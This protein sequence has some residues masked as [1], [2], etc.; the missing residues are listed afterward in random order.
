MGVVTEPPSIHTREHLGAGTIV[1]R[2]WRVP[3]VDNVTE[4]DCRVP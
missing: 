1:D 2:R 4:H 3:D